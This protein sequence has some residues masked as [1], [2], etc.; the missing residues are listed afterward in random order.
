MRRNKA[1]TKSPDRQTQ[2]LAG[3]KIG[4]REERSQV[5]KV[6]IPYEAPPGFLDGRSLRQFP[7]IA[8]LDFS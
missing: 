3:R 7:I 5:E 4:Q 6:V 1:V 8:F 2:P